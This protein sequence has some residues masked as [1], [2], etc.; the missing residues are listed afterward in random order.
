MGPMTMTLQLLSLLGTSFVEC[1]AQRYVSET[2]EKPISYSK[3]KNQLPKSMKNFLNPVEN[4][5]E[6]PTWSIDE[7]PPNFNRRLEKKTEQSNKSKKK[8]FH[9]W[10]QSQAASWA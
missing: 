4:W 9:Q 8:L 7:K 3:E 10:P 5:G 2:V 1:I 6:N